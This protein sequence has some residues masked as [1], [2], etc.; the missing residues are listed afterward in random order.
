MELGFFEVLISLYK[1]FGFILIVIIAFASV[2]LPPALAATED[3]PAPLLLRL[4]TP[5]VLAIC[6]KLLWLFD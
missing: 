5:V 6:Y 4:F 1:F 3:H 2:G